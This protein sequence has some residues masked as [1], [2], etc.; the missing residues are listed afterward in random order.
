M[1]KHLEMEF[2]PMS[3]LKNQY[4]N[5]SQKQSTMLNLEQ[6]L[7][8]TST[9]QVKSWHQEG[10]IWRGSHIFKAMIEFQS[11]LKCWQSWTVFDIVSWMLKEWIVWLG[12]SK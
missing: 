3:M 7:L 11:D 6:N 8:T 12:S 2:L 5:C 10:T 1:W 4:K 9:I